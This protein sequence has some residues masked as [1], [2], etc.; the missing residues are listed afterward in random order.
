M[1]LWLKIVADI[2]RQDKFITAGPVASWLWLAGLGYCRTAE[3]NGLIPKAVV[4]TLV[5]GMKGAYRHAAQLVSVGLWDEVVGGYAVHDYLDWNPSKEQIESLR[6]ADR[7]RKKDKPPS[8]IRPESERKPIARIRAGVNSPS[9]LNSSG[10]HSEALSDESAR[11]TTAISRPIRPYSQGLAGKHQ[12]TCRPNTWAACARGFCVPPFVAD[13][14]RVSADAAGLN[15]DEE[16]AA[17]V[18]LELDAHAGVI[19]GD[20]VKFWRSAWARR[21]GDASATRGNSRTG[22]SRDAGTEF[23]EERHGLTRGAR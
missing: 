10:S 12:V 23:L 17:C 20:P 2:A 14:W 13:E 18:R 9:T 11:E 16:I 22:D 1:P 7:E 19:A 4:P 15:A 6:A 8:G 5:P 3:N 21:H